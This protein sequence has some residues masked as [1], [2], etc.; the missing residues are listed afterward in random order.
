MQP[1]DYGRLYHCKEEST[2]CSGQFS[3]TD[4]AIK[5]K[6][7]DYNEFFHVKSGV[8]YHARLEDSRTVS[9]YDTRAGGTGT[10]SVLGETPITTHFAE[11]SSDTVILGYRPWQPTDP[12]RRVWFRI[13]KSK[14]L[15]R[16]NPAVRRFAR[17]A[18]AMRPRDSTLFELTCRN[19]IVRC[20]YGGSASFEI[21]LTEWWPVCELE[22]S[23]PRE[24]G[25]YLDNVHRILRFFSAAA[26]FQLTPSE[27][28][29][30]RFARD[31]VD[32][33]LEQGERDDQ[34]LVQYLWRQPS[35]RERDLHPMNSFVSAGD[36]REIRTMV[37]CLGAWL[38]RPAAWDEASTLMM[39]SLGL[40]DQLS[41]DR[42]L[43][44]CRWLDKIPGTP[45]E[46]ALN[47]DDA[48]KIAEAAIHEARIRD[49]GGLEGRIVSALR[50]LRYESNRDRFARLI[51]KVNRRFPDSPLDEGAVAHLLRAQEL[52][53]TVAHGLFEVDK[54]NAL[55]L[56][57][58][59]TSME[60][61]AYLLM[62]EGL[63]LSRAGRGR[64]TSSRL[65][66]DYRHAK[67]A[68]GVRTTGND[69]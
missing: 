29:I 44:S 53:G 32:Q 4:S 64:A 8:V 9:L 2:G 7:F 18:S 10:S 19:M 49:H 39:G 26:G 27:I 61:L 36:S 16:N 12:I 62:I 28:C 60:C 37:A 11:I 50:Y 24:I 42:L 20:W 63:P 59:L 17:Q 6:L 68:C 34:H 14:D 54:G 15:L 25:N 43:M 46:P 52:R 58:A 66:R 30:S 55:E 40:H 47:D 35:V 13:N 45:A 51:R 21:G 48:G 31:E 1:L 41:G 38:D 65:V 33:R 67:W 56:Q 69:R 5:I 22:F 23:E 3:I 57:C